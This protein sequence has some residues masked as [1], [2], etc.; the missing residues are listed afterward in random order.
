MAA[1]KKNFMAQ[2]RRHGNR[3]D[4]SEPVIL[5]QPVLCEGWAWDSRKKT[6]AM[7]RV[8]RYFS[9]RICIEQFEALIREIERHPEIHASKKKGRLTVTL[10]VQ[11]LVDGFQPE[12]G[13]ALFRILEKLGPRIDCPADQT[14]CGQPA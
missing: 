14:C 8:L 11:C 2:W 10:F 1:Y 5:K 7:V 4:R 13:E 6:L 9:V 3:L 12:V